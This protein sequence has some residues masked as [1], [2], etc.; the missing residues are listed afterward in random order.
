MSYN[1]IIGVYIITRILLIFLILIQSGRGGGLV[2]SMAGAESIFGTKTNSFMVKL[3]AVLATIFL[4]STILLAYLSKKQSQSL[5]ENYNVSKNKESAAPL[6]KKTSAT[7]NQTNQ[8]N[9]KTPEK[10][11]DTG[12]QGSESSDKK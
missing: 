7:P 9:Q 6:E 11:Q 2:D 5:L 1:R 10:E 8:E 12:V 4:G 3:T